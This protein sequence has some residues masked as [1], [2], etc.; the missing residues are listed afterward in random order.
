M[1]SKKGNK[2]LI[3]RALKEYLFS[4]KKEPYFISI[5]EDSIKIDKESKLDFSKELMSIQ[6]SPDYNCFTKAFI[7]DNLS[8]EGLSSDKKKALIE[9]VTLK[10][11]KFLAEAFIKKEYMSSKF[12]TKLEKFIERVQKNPET[13]AEVPVIDIIPIVLRA[14]EKLERDFLDSNDYLRKLFNN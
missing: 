5:L 2:D 9:F 7:K 6:V 12:I 14:V 4:Y 10:K 1:T 11:V 8:L 13:N 3:E